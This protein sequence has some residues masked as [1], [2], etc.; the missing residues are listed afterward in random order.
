VY[1]PVKAISSCSLSQF[2]R[3][4]AICFT[5][6]ALKV[7]RTHG[8]TEEALK[9]ICGSVVLAIGQAVLSLANLVG[10]RDSF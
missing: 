4:G 2:E 9:D 6:Y 1:E 7:I 3:N 10:T 8:M 5:V